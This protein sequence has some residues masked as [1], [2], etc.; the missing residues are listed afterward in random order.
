MEIGIPKEIKPHEYRVAATPGAVR[1]LVAAGHQVVCL[2][3]TS[4]AAD[5]N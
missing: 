4:D 3:Y 5:E 1:A 2:L